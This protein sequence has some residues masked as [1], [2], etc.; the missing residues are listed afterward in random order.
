MCGFSGKC[1][2]CVL[3]LILVS[4]SQPALSQEKGQDQPKFA[5][6]AILAPV[7]TNLAIT[8]VRHLS[9]TF[10]P[11]KAAKVADQ[12][13]GDTVQKLRGGASP[14]EALAH[15]A[16]NALVHSAQGLTQQLL[17]QGAGARQTHQIIG[18]FGG[19]ATSQRVLVNAAAGA[20]ANAASNAGSGVA[21]QQAINIALNSFQGGASVQEV[22][23]RVASHAGQ[24]LARQYLPQGV[25]QQAANALLNSLNAG[26]TP[27][28]AL[29]SA[30]AS[31]ASTVAIPQAV[32]LLVNSLQNGASPQ[33]AIAEATA[34]T[35]A[36]IA[37]NMAAQQATRAAANMSS[38]NA[39]PQAAPGS[40]AVVEAANAAADSAA[41]Q[42]A[43]TVVNSLQNGSTPREALADVLTQQAVNSALSSLKDGVQPQQA[44]VDAAV[45]A[46]ASMA[47]GIRVQQAASEAAGLLQVGEKP[48]NI[49]ENAT[50]IAHRTADIIDDQ[51]AMT[52]RAAIRYA[53]N[54]A[55]ASL[56]RG[57]SPQV[58]I[59]E[60][61]DVATRSVAAGTPAQF[62]QDATANAPCFFAGRRGQ[63]DLPNASKN[64]LRMAGCQQV[65]HFVNVGELRQAPA[66]TVVSSRA[67]RPLEYENGK[68]NYQA[69][70]I[71][72]LVV[73]NQGKPI[74]ERAIGDHFFSG[75]KF[76]LKIQTTF[77]GL[78]QLQHESPSGA[79]KRLFPKNGVDDFMINA[80]TVLILPVNK[81]NA[82]E[83]FGETG[84]EKFTFVVHDP[85]LTNASDAI[86][87]T[88]R[89]DTVAGSYYAQ[90][91]KP[92]RLPYF[93][94]SFS[95][96]H[97]PR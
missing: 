15:A 17:P 85:R 20:V 75:E 47:A 80:G 42:A 60:A 69:I 9:E 3:A 83:F 44:I 78:L 92:G 13:V 82:Y 63:R 57:A 94:Q 79:R 39:L 24:N 55:I 41:Q 65:S 49:L 66:S 2:A 61:A 12:A 51:D 74:A 50:A 34:N 8:G 58:A 56:S 25:S 7:L 84:D 59:A 21:A 87:T 76:R 70:K 32:E 95:I 10:L 89:Q 46:A 36:S 26:A 73:D 91:A 54:L 16:S 11:E 67:S 19:G 90:L 40:D 81:N 53:T 1:S 22:L 96:K 71:S 37:A 48:Q 52:T 14:Q 43:D 27:Q 86:N 5:L 23:A 33:A 6:S 4:G 28:E 72:I 38:G 18:G 35:A 31:T 45:N 97:R 68:P 29:A 62:Q 64:E 77:P 88:L 30:A 93:S